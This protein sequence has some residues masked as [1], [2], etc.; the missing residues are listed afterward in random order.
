MSFI[1]IKNVT[2]TFNGVNILKNMNI[3][4]RRRNCF[5]NTRKEW[6]WKICPYKYAE[7]NEGVQTR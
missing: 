5:R 3:T 1:E 6:I 2:K 7:G 4:V